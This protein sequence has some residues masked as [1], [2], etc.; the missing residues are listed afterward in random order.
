MTINYVKCEVDC[1]KKPDLHLIR[2][3]WILSRPNEL[4]PD[5]GKILELDIPVNELTDIVVECYVPILIREIICSMRDHRVWAR[6]S[7]VDDLTKWDIWEGCDENISSIKISGLYVDMMN[8][9]GKSDQDDYRMCLP[10]SYMTKFTLCLSLRSYMKLCV[11][12]HHIAMEAA[13]SGDPIS[14]LF[15]E[16]RDELVNVLDDQCRNLVRSGKVKYVELCPIPN[17]WPGHGSKRWGDSITVADIVP[18]ALRAQIIRHRTFLV[19]DSLRKFFSFDKLTSTIK[20]L[21]DVQITT[22]V[23]VAKEIVSK[24]SCWI[25]QTDIWLPIIEKMNSALSNEVEIVALPCDDGTCPYER[26]NQLRIEG[27]DPGVPCPMYSELYESPM[28]ED[29]M[30]K[31]LLYAAKRGNHKVFWY[32]QLNSVRDKGLVS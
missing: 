21:M 27:K 18:L 23:E 24:R 20:T 31:A 25:S 26:D 29:Q 17:R 15:A 14:E 22:T 7:R 19:T 32:G 13:I 5:L 12:F 16:V 28:T 4:D 6:T 9:K 11:Y 1:I 10:I 3:A 30:E 2:R 8:S